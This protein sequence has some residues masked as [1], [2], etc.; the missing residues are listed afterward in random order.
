MLIVITSVI[1]ILVQ[2]IQVNVAQQNSRNRISILK[3]SLLAAVF[4]WTIRWYIPGLCCFMIYTK[5]YW[6]TVKFS[7]VLFNKFETHFALRYTCVNA[8][9]QQF[10]LEDIFQRCNQR[11]SIISQQ[12]NSLCVL[13][14][15]LFITQ[16][17]E[18]VF[19]KFIYNKTAVLQNENIFPVST[20]V[21][22]AGKKRNKVSNGDDDDDYTPQSNKKRKQREYYRKRNGKG[23]KRSIQRNKVK[24][25]NSAQKREKR[26][27][28]LLFKNAENS[29]RAEKLAHVRKINPAYTKSE[30]Q[31]R[32]KKL[33]EKRKV[34]P[35]FKLSEKKRC[36]V[37]VA[38][39]RKLD[40]EF[41]LAEKVRCAEKVTKKRKN[42]PE[43]T[44]SE[45][46]VRAKKLVE[47][48]KNDPEFIKSENQVRAKKLAEKRKRNPEYKLAEKVRCAEKVTKKRKNDPEFTKSENQ[49]RAK[50]LVEKRKNDPEFKLSENK[51]RATKLAEKRMAD[52][53]FKKA[54]NQR[55]AEKISEQRT[56]NAGL[57]DDEQT[58]GNFWCQNTIPDHSQVMQFEKNPNLAVAV[59]RLMPGL[60]QDVSKVPNVGELC[61]NVDD[62]LVDDILG[63]WKTAM[64]H[65]SQLMIC[66]VCGKMGFAST[67]NSLTMASKYLNKFMFAD[68][69]ELPDPK[70]FHICSYNGK[71]YKLVPQGV[72]KASTTDTKNND[73]WV[74][75][76]CEDCHPVMA[77]TKVPVHS[78][79]FGDWGKLPD[80]PP[81]SLV[82][83]T[84]ISRY[85]IFGNIIKLKSV[86]GFSQSGLYGG[87]MLAMAIN[88]SNELTK[89]CSKF[90]RTDLPQ[91]IDVHYIGKS[92]GFKLVKELVKK[93][94]P[95][96]ANVTTCITWLRFLKQH[97]PL[98]TD[99]DIPESAQDVAHTQKIM[100]DQV[101]EI[102]NNATISDSSFIQSVE[103]TNTCDITKPKVDGSKSD[104]IFFN[105]GSSVVA[106][107]P[108]PE[109]T[110]KLL[111]NGLQ[112]KIVVA[113][114]APRTEHSPH[115]I[116]FPS[117]LANEFQSNPDILSG[118]FPWLFPYG[119]TKTRLCGS[120]TVKPIL[121]K[122]LMQFYDK[123]FSRETKLAFYLFN[124]KMRHETIH[125]VKLK[126]NGSSY[127]ANQFITKVNEEDFIDRLKNSV[128][129]PTSDDAKNL[130]NELVDTI[131]ITGSNIGF[132]PLERKNTLT[133]LYA[134]KHMFGLPFL[135]LTF[136]PNASSCP[137]VLKLA[138]GR[139]DCNELPDELLVEL[140]SF[141]ER[142]QYICDNPGAAAQVFHLVVDAFFKI[143]VGLPL[144]E[145][146]GRRT[147]VLHFDKTHR[148]G[149]FGK[150]NAS[151]G[152]IEA[153][154]R[155]ALHMHAL[156]F[157][158]IK[159]E[160]LTRWVHDE[161]FR[162]E[163]IKV[164]D[165]LVEAAIPS[166]ILNQQELHSEEDF[167]AAMQ[168]YPQS[169]ADVISNGQHVRKRFNVHK[170]TFTCYKGGR[171]YCRMAYKRQQ[172]DT[173]YISELFENK[174]DKKKG[175]PEQNVNGI[176]PPVN[177]SKHTIGY[178]DERALVF[179][180]RRPTEQ[181][182]SHVET[183]NVMASCLRC[184]TNVQVQL[185][186]VQAKYSIYYIGNYMSKNPVELGNL[187][188]LIYGAVLD[189]RKTK[190]RAKDAGTDI[191]NA[192]Y[193]IT[194]S[195][196]RMASMM[197]ISDQQ[198]MLSLMNH[199][200]YY[201]SHE[202]TNCYIWSAL[203]NINSSIKEK[204]V[205][206]DSSDEVPESDSMCLVGQAERSDSDVTRFV[207]EDEREGFSICQDSDKKIFKSDQYTQY[208]HR[209]H[210]LRH[211]GY[212]DYCS[213][214][215]ITKKSVSDSR[216]GPN[217]K[218]QGRPATKKFAFS[219]RHPQLHSNYYQYVRSKLYIPMVIGAG[220]PSYPGDPPED[221]KQFAAWETKAKRFVHFYA[222]LFLP[223]QEKFDPRDPTQP[224]LKIL[225][226][227]K[228]SWK[229]FMAILESWNSSPPEDN[230]YCN[231]YK[232][233]T[234][235][236]IQNMVWGLR[237][238]SK[239]QRILKLWRY[240][241]AN[242]KRDANT[243]SPYST[244]S[245]YGRETADI[246]DLVDLHTVLFE[247]QTLTQTS[248]RCHK[249]QLKYDL[250][251]DGLKTQCNLLFGD[252]KD[253]VAPQITKEWLDP[254]ISCKFMS[255]LTPLDC[256]VKLK[257]LQ[258]VKLPKVNNKPL[259]SDDVER[260]FREVSG[261]K[262]SDPSA[263]M[264]LSGDQ[265]SAINL[266]RTC[267]RQGAQFLGILHGGPGTGK[268]TICKIIEKLLGL[269]LAFTASTGVAASLNKG[270][271]IHSFIG[272]NWHRLANCTKF[273]K[274]NNAGKQYV[275]QEQ[276]KNI[277][278]LVI[279]EISMV[280]SEMLVEIDTKLRAAKNNDKPFGG[281]HVLLV[282]DFYQFPPVN[283]A[284]DNPPLYTGL[285]NLATKTGHMSKTA[286]QGASLFKLFKLMQLKTQNR[287]SDPLHLELIEN[288]RGASKETPIKKELLRRVKPLSQEDIANDPDWRF[289]PI[290][291]TTN[292]MRHHINKQKLRLFAIENKR[293]VLR[294][295]C[296]YKK[297]KQTAVLPFGTYDSLE[298]TVPD[299]VQYF[300]RGAK[301]S[302]LV[303]TNPTQGLSN[304]TEATFHSVVFGKDADLPD[305]E[306]RMA[307]EIIDVPLPDY[308]II[309]VNGVFVPVRRDLIAFKIPGR[310]DEYQRHAHAVSAAYSLT[311]HKCQGKT[312]EKVVLAITKSTTSRIMRHSINGIYVGLSRVE[313]G[314]N[315]RF[316]P[317]SDIDLDAICQMKNNPILPLWLGNYDSGGTWKD[318]GLQEV[319]ELNKTRA[320][321][322]LKHVPSL[323]LL[324]L[325]KLK[326]LCS[327][328]GLDL[329][330]ESGAKKKD[331]IE[332]L[333][334]SF[335]RSKSIAFNCGDL[336]KYIDAKKLELLGL[337]KLQSLR[338][339][340]LRQY[341]MVFGIDVTATT[342]KNA[343]VK[344]L[345]ALIGPC[346]HSNPA[347]KPE[348]DDA[349]CD[350]NPLHS[351]L[352]GLPP[353]PDLGSGSSD[354]AGKGRAGDELSGDA[355]TGV[356]AH[357][358]FTNTK[359]LCYLES[360]LPILKIAV[361]Q[362]SRLA[363]FWA[364]QSDAIFGLFSQC[365]AAMGLNAN[366]WDFI[367]EKIGFHM[368]SS[369]AFSSITG[370]LCGGFE[371]PWVST[372]S[373][374]FAVLAGLEASSNNFCSV[375]GA[376]LLQ[377][378]LCNYCGEAP[379]PTEHYFVLETQ[380]LKD[381][382]G[383]DQLP[384]GSAIQQYLHPR[385]RA[386][387]C[388]TCNFEN[389]E[390]HENY[391][392]KD[393]LIISTENDP[394]L[395]QFPQT[396]SL[397]NTTYSFIGFNR[398][399]DQCHWNGIVRDPIS[400]RVFDFES[401]TTTKIEIDSRDDYYSPN[402]VYYYY[403]RGE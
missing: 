342:K 185:T 144:N 116:K 387:T 33:V 277:D 155:G 399:V 176:S 227:H 371:Q 125:N 53:N 298:N 219:P 333:K 310:R 66:G 262:P 280:T 395:Y 236:I 7:V 101:D 175:K 286:I 356:A 42:D 235:N 1:L 360:L 329:G 188:S 348:K 368:I 162:K 163:I 330:Y 95:L 104:R 319:S 90:P 25:A 388:Q 264:K 208:L 318:C 276:F 352:P 380:Y 130:L 222:L 220:P 375:I 166:G 118:A 224:N 373:N 249:N 398:F 16:V 22:G 92:K 200:S 45:N 252:P 148:G 383:N 85:A 296:P 75:N 303:N 127:R 13:I 123:R 24:A 150:V 377:L 28:E 229:N 361:S 34:D 36:A 96:V 173:S 27:K 245:G 396:F 258:E 278:M 147:G 167:P 149:I 57:K 285:V 326:E 301:C 275:M 119:L 345:T 169:A 78:I 212:Y 251:M 263:S 272:L 389:A 379:S 291:V 168:N 59:L 309:E 202:F 315:I 79:A 43:F 297:G 378:K 364:D 189:A 93:E 325:T 287:C 121:V 8:D 46:Q 49:V 20:L 196:N 341:A 70:R 11:W 214:I 288:I 282:G 250:F 126:I 336:K 335:L 40:P 357:P 382:F 274:N 290:M 154:A 302:L 299:L 381:A 17:L 332:N 392:G 211:L 135:W 2:L 254:A 97:H 124:Q 136:S 143:L 37:K 228:D 159:P 39:K 82:E 14:D 226:W 234:F 334:D 401:K 247:A 77:R 246:A 73:S 111:L 205:K 248:T 372:F 320:L 391:I 322:F 242:R 156:L 99:V 74:V 107:L 172:S 94:G 293:H 26:N 133:H 84:C 6:A 338:P 98:Y 170:C 50:K 240:L 256:E 321:Q 324:D 267:T 186:D 349:P 225:P 206:P 194:K 55:R 374:P 239:N 363:Q 217:K 158:E 232:R 300:V 117:T 369:P 216:S 89:L 283:H 253:M 359:N 81:L 160:I 269:K 15:C 132:S 346:N 314:D 180:L 164:L 273:K 192:K 131:S 347:G 400:K 358:F 38:K 243:L 393:L 108:N 52:P 257:E 207:G 80:L 385:H 270:Q 223:W 47:K 23:R 386:F 41:K 355:E 261:K 317:Y 362:N 129:D 56:N 12:M 141:K 313:R 337:G 367:K 311:Y 316:L 9:H 266:I 255:D 238:S 351:E 21:G 312:L 327:R 67:F 403:L 343:I 112:K 339:S 102:L 366:N 109:D 134:L 86:C 91:L 384:P 187:F 151:Y 183:N 279:D 230:I 218:G 241:H 44:K 268:T 191:R 120:G 165:N 307:G 72:E 31:V 105:L 370:G 190:S 157:G 115:K 114:E 3:V 295:L 306:N 209:G 353:S 260:L 340:V 110:A 153:Q 146:K 19:C 35:E 139:V 365:F 71:N 100:D 62:D 32:A 106:P 233:S 201:S 237:V 203:R 51:V 197:E 354:T 63:R 344:Q 231:W 305:M 289:A 271:T 122:T 178:K 323:D 128:D 179:G 221:S 5:S 137:M 18:I 4:I 174:T 210:K 259:T 145:Y 328:K 138:R 68:D 294:W 30:N 142:Y 304:G 140:P 376:D 198:V 58:Y 60:I 292:K 397:A 87:H 402:A 54:E 184:N 64:G 182:R 171:K 103:L 177:K 195:L 161:Q 308:V 10:N 281:V 350:G 181:D 48:R 390:H 213:L 113:D 215:Q 199:K 29:I 69:E 331:L 244:F 76:L 284:K 83:K 152:I 265:L 193:I 394:T 61:K 65:D 204:E 88:G